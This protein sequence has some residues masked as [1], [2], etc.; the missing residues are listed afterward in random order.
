MR[1]LRKNRISIDIDNDN[2]FNLLK[3]YYNMKNMFEHVLTKKTLH[4]YHIMAYHK[5]RT[6]ELNM[7]IRNI[8][9]DC[10]NRLELDTWRLN[11]FE[12]DLIE[13]LFEEKILYGVKGVEEDF[14][15]LSKPFWEV[16]NHV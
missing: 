12:P 15:I 7:H 8:L 16:K 3:T 4:G 2:Q 11:E 9:G 13:T 6:S 1:F 14:N 10:C 5:N